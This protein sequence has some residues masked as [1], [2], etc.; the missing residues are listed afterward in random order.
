[1]TPVSANSSGPTGNPY[2]GLATQR[3][4]RTLVLLGAGRRQAADCGGSEL[5][6]RGLALGQPIVVQR[7]LGAVVDHASPLEQVEQADA[8][9]VQ[10]IGPVLGVQGGQANQTG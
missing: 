8:N 3:Y 1:M 2:A 4:G 9:H 7:E 5:R 10:H 6:E